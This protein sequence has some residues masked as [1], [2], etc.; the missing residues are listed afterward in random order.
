VITKPRRR[1][2]RAVHRRRP[3]ADHGRRRAR[4]ARVPR[5]KRFPQLAALAGEQSPADGVR[6]CVNA[7]EPAQRFDRVMKQAV[8]GD[9]RS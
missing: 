3:A 2:A 9:A 5:R 4:R 1:G 7:A 8:V 6:V